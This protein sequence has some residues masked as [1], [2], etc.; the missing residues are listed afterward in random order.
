MNGGFEEGHNVGNGWKIFPN[1]LGW[2][3]DANGIEIGHGRIYNSKW[4]AGTHVVELDAKKNSDIS[5]SI[6]LDSQFKVSEE[7]SQ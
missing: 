2:T 3:C 6:F 1:I 7:D 4:P 5:Q